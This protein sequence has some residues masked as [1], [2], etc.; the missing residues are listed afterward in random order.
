MVITATLLTC[1]AWFDVCLSWG[2]TEHWSSVAA[3]LVELPVAMLLATTAVIV[4]R[5][6]C[7]FIAQLRGQD[8]TPVPLWRQPMIH[9]ASTR[10]GPRVEATDRATERRQHRLRATTHQCACRARGRQSC[11]RGSRDSASSGRRRMTKF[12]VPDLGHA[13]ATTFGS[14][15]RGR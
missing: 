6:S 15:Y 5:R 7:T 11:G 12:A 9:V 13:L 3:A 1:D 2:T 14:L 4:M 8:P 10:A